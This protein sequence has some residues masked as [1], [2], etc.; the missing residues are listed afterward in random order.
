MLSQVLCFTIVVKS[1]TSLNNKL[2]PPIHDAVE[3]A[4]V[5][6]CGELAKAARLFFSVL[7]KVS[8]KDSVSL[9]TCSFYCCFIRKMLLTCIVKL[10]SLITRA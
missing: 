6:S 1:E 2:D 3:S 4:F 7:K 5:H 10:V 8:S 9:K